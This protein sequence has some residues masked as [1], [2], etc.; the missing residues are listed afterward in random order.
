MVRTVQCA[1]LAELDFVIDEATVAEN[2]VG[3]LVALPHIVVVDADNLTVSV[4]EYPHP[5]QPEQS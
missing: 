1:D 4:F 5:K 2:A 3:E